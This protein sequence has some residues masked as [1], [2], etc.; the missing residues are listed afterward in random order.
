M[1]PYPSSNQA[2]V[3]LIQPGDT[4]CLKTPVWRETDYRPFSVGLNYQD[5]GVYCDYSKASGGESKACIQ[6]KFNIDSPGVLTGCP[7]QPF[8][9]PG[10]TKTSRFGSS[11]LEGSFTEYHAGIPQHR[12]KLLEPSVLSIDTTSLEL[13]DSF[14]VP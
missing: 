14:W 10:K 8:L 3:F 9:F 2:Q 13:L 11:S 6:S 5:N 4:S 12:H 7:Q 1:S